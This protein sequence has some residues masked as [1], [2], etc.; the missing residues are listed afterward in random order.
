VRAIYAAAPADARADA[1]CKGKGEGA[2]GG[3]VRGGG[4]GGGCGDGGD[5]DEEEKEE[6]DE[7]DEEEEEEAEAAALLAAAGGGYRMSGWSEV[8]VAATLAGPVFC[9]DCANCGPAIAVSSDGLS[10]S[11][12]S[13]E[14]W[15]TVRGT[16]PPAALAFTTRI[17]LH[18]PTLLPHLLPGAEPFSVHYN[19]Q[20]LT[21]L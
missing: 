18:L 16:E 3:G 12:G 19:T 2:R 7:E 8:L 20:C 1:H 15:A 17:S 10:A 11:F 21:A 6:E 5:G 13:S 4:G 14:S 9:F